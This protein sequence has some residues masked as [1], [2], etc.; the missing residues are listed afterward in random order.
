[1]PNRMEVDATGHPAP[2]GPSTATGSVATV[3]GSGRRG[4][5]PEAGA[6]RRGRPTDRSA[7]ETRSA[8]LLAAQRLFGESGY[9]GASMEAIAAACGVN[10]R[11]VYYHFDSKRDLFDAATEEAFRRFGEEVLARVFC[12]STL[13]ERV[14]GYLDVYRVLHAGDPHL[15][16]FIG[17]VLVENLSQGAGTVATGSPSGG[18]LGSLLEVLVDEA[19]ANEEVHPALDRDG[20]VRLLAAVGM[21]LSLASQGEAAAFLASLDALELLLGGELFADP[22]GPAAPAD[23]VRDEVPPP[24]PPAARGR[25]TRT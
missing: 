3:E 4:S 9:R 11:A 14:G 20:A 15:V 19:M 12:H 25:S 24:T 22:P 10:A 13:R 2:P 18:L 8:L 6:R 23:A 7:Q 17:M 16:P 21:G 5:E 1:M